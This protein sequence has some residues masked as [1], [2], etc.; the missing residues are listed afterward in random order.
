MPTPPHMCALPQDR[1]CSQLTQDLF[2]PFQASCPASKS[3]L[4]GVGE[5]AEVET[6]RNGTAPRRLDSTRGI[7]QNDSGLGCCD[8]GQVLQ[9]LPTQSVARGPADLGIDMKCTISGRLHLNQM[10]SQVQEDMLTPRASGN[11]HVAA[12]TAATATP[13][14]PG[15][16]TSPP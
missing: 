3:Q 5:A 10:P 16:P 14:A 13:R 6:A 8:C 9:D 12:G 4:Q 7:W 15:S 1:R 11:R 2:S